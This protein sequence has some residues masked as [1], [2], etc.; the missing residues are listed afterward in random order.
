MNIFYIQKGFH[1]DLWLS[2][3][4]SDSVGH[5]IEHGQQL[6][7]IRLACTLNLTDK[8]TPLSIMEDYI[9]NAKE[10]AQEILSMESDSESL[11]C[12]FL[13]SS[14]LIYIFY[15]F[16]Y[17]KFQFRVNM[18]GRIVHSCALEHVALHVAELEKKTIF[19]FL[20]LWFKGKQLVFPA[21]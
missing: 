13:C 14:Y 11:V 16:F 19:L 18:N 5:L 7:A 15:S 2:L 9:Q 8:Y 1:V 21:L 17:P 6:V 20:I 12:P 10:T 3:I 4:I